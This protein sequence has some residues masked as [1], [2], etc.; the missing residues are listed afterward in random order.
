MAEYPTTRPIFSG[1]ASGG[2]MGTKPC[3][4]PILI[5]LQV[6]Y[7]KFQDECLKDGWKIV[8]VNVENSEK[9]MNL[10]KDR[11]TK[12]CLD[13]LQMVTKDGNGAIKDITRTI[14]GEYYW[15]ADISSFKSVIVDIHVLSL[16][17]VRAW[18]SWSMGR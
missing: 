9:L 5:G 8:S 15:D 16:D 13:P 12:F 10:F 7:H 17:Q 2:E 14:N 4:E 3:Y 6:P 1:F 11:Q 18:S